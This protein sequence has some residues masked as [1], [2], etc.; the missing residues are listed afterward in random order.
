MFIKKEIIEKSRQDGEYEK[1]KFENM[2]GRS[3]CY[4]HKLFSV[5]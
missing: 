5:T 2:V 1:R 4:L 3:D